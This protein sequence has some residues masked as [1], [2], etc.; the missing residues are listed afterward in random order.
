MNDSFKFHTC[1][2]CG[3]EMPDAP[4]GLCP[5]CLMA[6][7]M[8]ATVAGDEHAAAPLTPEE[9]APHFPQLE[10]LSCLGRGGMGIVYKARQKTLNRFVALKLLAPERSDDPLFAE[11]FTKEAQALAALNHPHIVSIYDFGEAGGFFYLLMEFVDGMNLRQLLKAKKLTPKEALSIVPPIC[12]ALQCAH[13]HGIV[14]RDIKPENLLIDKAGTVKIADFGIAKIVGDVSHEAEV[15]HGPS[16]MSA[17][18]GT[19]EYAAPEQ[20]DHSPNT[21]PRADIYS[22][23]VVLYEMLTGERPSGDII[24]PS[25]RV[26]VDVRIDE[27]VLRALGKTPELRF[28]TAAE[29]RTRVEMLTTKTAAEE[30][31]IP[32][33]MAGWMA[34][35]EGKRAFVR[36][37]LFLT[38]ITLTFCFGWIDR[39]VKSSGPD[40]GTG[41]I[42]HE[43]RLLVG[44]GK[45]WLTEVEQRNQK[46]RQSWN[47]TDYSAPS[48]FL[49][50]AAVAVWILLL[51]LVIVEQGRGLIR[52]R[53]IPDAEGRSRILWPN[54]VA[55][56]LGAATAV[57][58][59]NLLLIAFV[60]AFGRGAPPVLPSLLFSVMMP[61]VVV[62]MGLRSPHRPAPMAGVERSRPTELA[63][64]IRALFGAALGMS[65]W[66]PV[67]SI[68]SDWNRTG[69]VLSGSAS[70]FI[71][72]TAALLW[73][74]RH[75]IPALTGLLILLA[76]GFVAT[77]VFVL[78]AHEYGLTVL[79]S[80]PGGRMVSP[81]RLVWLL[82]LFPAMAVWFLFRYQK[83]GEGSPPPAV[84]GAV[85]P[86]KRSWWRGHRASAALVIVIVVILRTWVL[87]AFTVTTDAVAP[88]IP[89]GSKVLVWKHPGHLSSGDLII[90]K[91]DGRANIGRVASADVD[92]VKVRRNGQADAGIPRDAVVGKV[93]SVFW[94]T[95]PGPGGAEGAPTGDSPGIVPAIAL[96]LLIALALFGPGL[97]PR[98]TRASKRP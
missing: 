2:Q 73:N 50:L 3:A 16:P 5:R 68:L 58:L 37:V 29:F 59:V 74:R 49:G 25:K 10:I 88:E 62:L 80:W 31:A 34:W 11:R 93:F 14:H 45:P 51:R 85:T 61:M 65:L 70:L 33:P 95:S 36:G 17:A 53:T 35:P 71:L 15:S 19:P 77:F 12:E 67:A 40:F 48:F 75:R 28:A 8:Q 86:A 13:D 43:T 26:Q 52:L 66:M 81:L 38:A 94:R 87:M 30:P 83:Q 18:V 69:L 46:G 63:W 57:G 76:A 22:L 64:N 1:R 41:A 98:V 7:V 84:P 20:V 92:R 21:D 79:S 55:G 32:A 56:G 54:V 90:Y 6:E 60:A 47:Q 82:G 72:A 91:A 39:E 9:L 4:E 96:A 23:G 44:I 78:A 42:Q 89:Q 24:P 97:I 27:I